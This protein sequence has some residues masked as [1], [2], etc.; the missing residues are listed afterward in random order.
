MIANRLAN[1]LY[2][3]F[4]EQIALGNWPVGRRLPPEMR[5]G[6]MFSASRPVVR[7][8]LGQLKED[9]IITSRQGSGNYVVRSPAVEFLT[10]ASVGNIAELLRC[11]EFRVGLEGEAAALAAIRRTDQDLALIEEKLLVARELVEP[12]DP[13][14]DAD[15][16]FHLSVALASNNDFYVTTFRSL[17]EQALYGMKLARNLSLAKNLARAATVQEEHTVVFNAIRDRQPDLARS[18]LRAHIECT[19]AR[20]LGA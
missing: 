2:D 13:G 11:F 18:A 17:R 10:F 3:Q 8:A 6:E 19:R 5:L 16:E 20:I 1:Q 12:V 7:Q 9:G 14:T 15:F 4:L